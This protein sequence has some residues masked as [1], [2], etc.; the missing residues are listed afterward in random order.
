MVNIWT[1]ISD[2][3]A[4]GE[5]AVLATLMEGER[6]GATG[7]YTVTGQLIT[8]EDVGFQGRA[9]LDEAKTNLYIEELIPRPALVIFGGG[10]VAVPVA[11]IGKLTDFEVI[12]NDD[13]PEFADISRFPD[14]DLVLAM[15]HEQA[16][17]QLNINSRHYI[18]I[19]TRGHVH[20]R[21][22]LVR[23]LRTDAAYIGMIGSKKKAKEVKEWLVE[24]GFSPGDIRRVF[25]P[26]G[27][28]INAQT[29]EEI[30]V[31]ILA[32]V[33]KERSKRPAPANL[34]EITTAIKIKPQGETWGLV[35][36]VQASGST[37][38]GVGSRMLVKPDGSIIG[39]VGGGPGEKEAEEIALEVISTN[40]PRLVPFKLN[41]TLA[42]GQG[43]I[44][45]G[46]FTMFIQ[47][48]Q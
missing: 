33:L 6:S 15:S 22:C 39:T 25:S 1:K 29:P 27:L 46:N 36:I 47:P 14:A 23:A 13:R 45:G 38:R 5:T 21:D 32:E 20:D 37:P 26:I 30:G 12:V 17:A 43:M 9:E 16:F 2:I 48:I 7:L 31:S 4:V 24:Q 34:G 18:V 3:L 35:T 8:G 44:C 11:K 41:S 42:A 40:T 28:E 19:V 10:H